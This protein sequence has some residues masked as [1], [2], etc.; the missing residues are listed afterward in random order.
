MFNFS[1]RYGGRRPD[2]KTACP[3]PCEGMGVYPDMKPGV[4][5]SKTKFKT[6]P[7]C[8][9]TGKRPVRRRKA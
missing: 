1:D 8:K 4:P 5:A 3:G 6:C 7:V 2:P 9:G